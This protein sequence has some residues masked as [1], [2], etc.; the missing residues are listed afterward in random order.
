MTQEHIFCGYCNKI[1]VHEVQ[2]ERQPLSNREKDIA[3]CTECKNEFTYFPLGEKDVN[4]NTI[5]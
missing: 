2:A 3:S 5:N 1:T 4:V